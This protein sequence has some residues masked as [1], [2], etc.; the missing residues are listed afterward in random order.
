MS[1]T[2]AVKFQSLLILCGDFN[3][4]EILTVSLTSIPGASLHCNFIQ[5][6]LLVQLVCHSTR[7]DL[8]SVID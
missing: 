3:V 7:S 1:S 8:R 5:D 4:P 2:L 6:N